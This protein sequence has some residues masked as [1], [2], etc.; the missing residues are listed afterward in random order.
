MKVTLKDNGGEYVIP[1][2]TELDDN[3]KVVKLNVGKHCL[4]VSSKDVVKVDP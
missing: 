1:D 3:G 4:F 2:V